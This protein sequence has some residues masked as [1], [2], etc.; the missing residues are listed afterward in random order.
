MSTVTSTSGEPSSWMARWTTMLSIHV[1]V[2]TCNI[3]EALQPP[4]VGNQRSN[5]LDHAVREVKLG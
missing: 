4:V 2:A 1:T 5:V 3:L